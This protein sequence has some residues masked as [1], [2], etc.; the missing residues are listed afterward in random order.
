MPARSP[1]RS[2][3]G[4]TRSTVVRG[5]EVEFEHHQVA[6]AQVRDDR[7]GGG[8]HG[9]QSARLSGRTGVGTAI[10]KA[11]AGP[12]CRRPAGCRRKAACTSVRSPGSSMCSSPCAAAR[13]DA[14]VDI[15]AVTCRPL[16]AK[17]LAI[18]R[19]M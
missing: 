7:L 17:V 18:G 8:H 3:I 1:E 2:R 12:G 9:A 19:P 4:A 11:S 10:R 14:L 15:H 6:G 16:L 13:D 5:G